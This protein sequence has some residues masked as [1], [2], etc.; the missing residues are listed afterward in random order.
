MTDP[1]VV[2]PKPNRAKVYGAV[3]CMIAT[4]GCIGGSASQS[5]GVTEASTFLFLAG[6]GTFVVGRLRQ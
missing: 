1:I 5:P 6:L 2:T 3:L 4:I